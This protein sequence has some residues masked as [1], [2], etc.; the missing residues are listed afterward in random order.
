MQ[1]ALRVRSRLFAECWPV[2][3]HFRTGGKTHTCGYEIVCPG[4]L[5]WAT[6]WSV[7]SAPAR[8]PVAPTALGVTSLTNATQVAR[9]VE[10]HERSDILHS[11]IVVQTLEVLAPR[12]FDDERR[13]S[14]AYKDPVEQE[15][16][17]PAAPVLEGV[18]P[19]EFCM[20][21]N[22]YAH[23]VWFVLCVRMILIE[24]SD[25]LSDFVEEVRELAFDSVSVD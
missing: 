17:C 5:D 12:R 25:R 15:P 11:V 19:H 6:H 23:R 3:P 22:R 24:A 8:R 7:H 20:R 13:E 21:P 2:G 14:Q 18:N 10:V 9:E 16:T 1:D 4:P